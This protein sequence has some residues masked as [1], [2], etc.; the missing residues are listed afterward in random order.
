MKRGIEL[1][2][3]NGKVAKIIC[4]NLREYNEYMRLIKENHKGCS[5]RFKTFYNYEDVENW[6]LNVLNV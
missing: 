6:L 3:P 4:F 1:D 5:Y 2:L